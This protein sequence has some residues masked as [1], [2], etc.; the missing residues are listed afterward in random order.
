MSSPTPAPVTGQPGQLLERLAAALRALS[1]LPGEAFDYVSSILAS[2]LHLT[3]EPGRDGREAF[4][5]AAVGRLR[6]TVSTGI[7]EDLL[8]IGVRDT[9]D[10]DL[11]RQTK[12][13]EETDGPRA[14]ARRRIERVLE[15]QAELEKYVELAREAAP[16]TVVTGDEVREHLGRILERGFPSRFD[17]DGVMSWWSMDKAWADAVD[18]Y[19]SDEVVNEWVDRNLRS[20]GD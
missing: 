8:V 9:I 2:K 3:V 16:G 10:L 14:E 15:D 12:G 5:D 19:V 18:L 6:E 13:T 11:R 1:E 20:S 17:P 4:I 7:G